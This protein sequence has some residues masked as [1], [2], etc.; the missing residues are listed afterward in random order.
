MFIPLSQKC[1]ELYNFLYIDLAFWS[2]G[3][4]LQKTKNFLY[5]FICFSIFP[6]FVFFFILAINAHLAYDIFL[7]VL[8]F[9]V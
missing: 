2:V 8:F 6:I 7:S 9:F 3:A 1:L 5:F 4:N